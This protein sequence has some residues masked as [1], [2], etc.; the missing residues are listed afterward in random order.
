MGFAAP[1]GEPCSGWY[2]RRDWGLQSRMV[3]S[4]RALA[5]RAFW[6]VAVPLDPQQLTKMHGECRMAGRTRRCEGVSAWVAIAPAAEVYGRR[7]V[8]QQ[9]ERARSSE[10]GPVN[11]GDMPRGGGEM[12][13]HAQ[14]GHE[15]PDGTKSCTY[16]GAPIV[17]GRLPPGGGATLVMDGIVTWPGA[18][19][20]LSAATTATATEATTLASTEARRL[21][22]APQ[23]Q[24]P[25]PRTPRRHPRPPRPCAVASRLSRPRCISEIRWEG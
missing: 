4:I 24:P 9:G 15:V 18:T 5:A 25:Q 3:R 13:F 22:R 23:P 1:Q 2:D 16:C 12:A 20:A 17:G 19:G 21:P 11:C 14:R 7:A 8:A 10:V 6:S